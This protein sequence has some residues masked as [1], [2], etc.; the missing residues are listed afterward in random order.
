MS[1]LP[2]IES[3]MSEVPEVVGTALKAIGDEVAKLGSMLEALA[4]RMDKL[5]KPAG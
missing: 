1:F 2:I 3:A 4:A 5:D